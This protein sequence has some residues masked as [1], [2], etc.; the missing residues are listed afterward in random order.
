[1][2]ALAASCA[3]TDGLLAAFKVRKSCMSGSEEQITLKSCEPA[4]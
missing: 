3:A 2:A 4:I 1:L